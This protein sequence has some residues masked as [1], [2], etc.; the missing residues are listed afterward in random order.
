MIVCRSSSNLKDGDFRP[1]HELPGRS[2]GDR[3]ST[4]QQTISQLPFLVSITN[5]FFVTWKLLTTGKSTDPLPDTLTRLRVP[6]ALDLLKRLSG[7]DTMAN[8]SDAI[9]GLTSLIKQWN[10]FDQR[11]AARGTPRRSA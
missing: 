11:L 8:F 1:K 3:L 2:Y 5:N 10:S 7:V 4:K 6:A 9:E